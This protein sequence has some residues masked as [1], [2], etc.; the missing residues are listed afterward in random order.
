MECG[1]YSDCGRCSEEEQASP[2]ELT[3]IPCPPSTMPLEFAPYS[4]SGVLIHLV[5]A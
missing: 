1:S 5:S 4:P 3:H 2:N